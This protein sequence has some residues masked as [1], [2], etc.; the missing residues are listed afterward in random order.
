MSEWISVKDQ[1]PE[2][3]G[4]E[5]ICSYHR[6]GEEKA[7]VSTMAYGS[8][9]DSRVDYWHEVDDPSRPYKHLAVTHWMPLPAPP[10]TPEK[11]D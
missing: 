5:V 2:Q 10:S 3:L 9:F 6:K 4:E 11:E 7:Y 1:L 8:A